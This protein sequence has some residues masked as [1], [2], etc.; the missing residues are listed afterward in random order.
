MKADEVLLVGLKRS[1][2]AISKTNG[3]IVWSTKLPSGLSQEFVTL[4]C[5]G[6]TVFACS[7]GYLH[8]LDLESGR[9]LWSN[10]LRG[11]GQGLAT[12]CFPGGTNGPEAAAAQAQRNHAAAACSAA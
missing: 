3:Q 12:I 1:V 11:Y 6:A 5:D 2:L 9:L 4:A 8:A 7:S 10:G